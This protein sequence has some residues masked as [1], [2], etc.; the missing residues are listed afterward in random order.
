VQS[1]G[2]DYKKKNKSMS[3]KRL[4]QNVGI[5]PETVYL[6]NF[7]A[8]PPIERRANKRNL[9]MRIFC[10]LCCCDTNDIGEQDHLIKL[11]DD[12]IAFY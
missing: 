12:E 1:S 9:C 7:G 3:K 8:E 2:G 4:P 11:N 5:D 10:L 6:M